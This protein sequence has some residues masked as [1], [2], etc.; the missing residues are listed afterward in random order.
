MGAARVAFGRGLVAAGST[1]GAFSLGMVG[2]LSLARSGAS[3][4]VTANN[5]AGQSGGVVAILDSSAEVLAFYGVDVVA[6]YAQRGGV[7]YLS[8]GSILTTNSSVFTANSA[9]FGGAF[10]IDANARYTSAGDVAKLH[11]TSQSPLHEW[12]VSV[13]SPMQLA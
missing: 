3:A 2:L 1:G 10:Y 4:L 5:T 9:T 11:S 7:G 12:H 6:N 8:G 13:A